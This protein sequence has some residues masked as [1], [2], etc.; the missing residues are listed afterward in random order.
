M[1]WSGSAPSQTFTRTDGTRTGDTAWTQAAAANVNI[2]ASDHDTHDSDLADGIESCLK[3]D[4]GNTAT[5]D[6]PMGGFTLTNISAA[7]ARTEPARFADVQDN[8]GHYISTVGGTADVITLTPTIPITAYVAGQ[9]YQFI[10]GGTNTGAVTVNIS[11]V[12]AKD[13]KARDASFSAL[14]AGTLVSGVMQDMIY[15]GTRF[16]YIGAGADITL[17]GDVTGSGSG[18]VALT[19]GND[20][21]TYAKM[22]NVTATSRVL[23][24]IT[25][26]AGD[27]E[28]LTAANLKTILSLAVADVSGA[29]PLASPTFT[30]VPA[31]VTA[32]ADTNTTQIATTAYVIGQ[33]SAT[34]P[35]ASGTAA[36]GSSNKWAAANHVHPFSVAL[37]GGV[38]NSANYN[39]TTGVLTIDWTG[40]GTGGSCFPA[41][42]LVQMADG[43]QRGITEIAKGDLLWSPSGTAR[44]E[45]LRETNLGGR[46]YWRMMDSSIFWSD[47]HS[48]AV[49]RNDDRRLWSMNIDRLQGEAIAGEIGGLDDWEWMYEG[50]AGKA[51][52]FLTVSGRR[53]NAP[54][55]VRNGIKP[56]MPLYV[57]MT[58]NG[59]LI[60]VN[61][62]IVGAGVDSAKCDYKTLLRGMG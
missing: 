3:K 59:E 46:T 31:S 53:I 22:Q 13:L 15:D 41:G 4:G 42:S 52:W 37:G 1:P 35:S 44:V 19:I 49:E 51:E 7:G 12:G 56:A 33:K 60:A 16:Q 62:Y 14:A 32:A 23:G 29:A 34:A 2:K 5:N 45:Y 28:E 6:I 36:I 57:P 8:L 9:R 54:V 58:T 55:R 43:T 38:G 30:G 20:K 25:S 47:E 26:G 21:V 27:V 24:R 48:F 61:G 50:E 10:A 11:G 17:T 39:P 40:G 18:S